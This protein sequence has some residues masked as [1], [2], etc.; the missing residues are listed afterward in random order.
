MAGERGGNGQLR[1][2]AA[3]NGGEAELVL[4]RDFLV[5]A[6]LAARLERIEGV[7]A[8]TPF[9]G[10]SAEACARFLN[11]CVIPAKAGIHTA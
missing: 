2:K 10:R 4:G 6:E 8:V 7:T 9:S 11:L 5:D 1:L 3:W